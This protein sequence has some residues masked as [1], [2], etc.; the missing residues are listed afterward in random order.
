MF[1]LTFDVPTPDGSQAP[2]TV[3]CQSFLAQKD[4][5]NPGGYI[6]TRHANGKHN[7]HLTLSDIK[8]ETLV[9]E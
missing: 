4:K 9:V 5:Y 7:W 8:V 2:T 6:T 3:F 1:K